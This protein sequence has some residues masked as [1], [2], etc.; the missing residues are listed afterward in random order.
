M[1]IRG[2]WRGGGLEQ[3]LVTSVGQKYSWEREGNEI[4]KKKKERNLELSLSKDQY[5]DEPKIPE[6]K[7]RYLKRLS[8]ELTRNLRESEFRIE[9]RKRRSKC[10]SISFL[11]QKK[12]QEETPERKDLKKRR[13]SRPSH[14]QGNG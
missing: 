8:A 1:K 10:T 12:T 9:T 7:E 4:K 3:G 5:G 2:E 14:N 13:Q 11:R 6:G